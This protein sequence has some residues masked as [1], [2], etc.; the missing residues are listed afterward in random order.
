MYVSE[1]KRKV[2]KLDYLF[3]VC[4]SIVGVVKYES[5]TPFDEN[6]HRSGSA[7]SVLMKITPLE[8]AGLVEKTV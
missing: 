2:V 1:V 8:K 6:T 4:D 3:A 7:S 5:S